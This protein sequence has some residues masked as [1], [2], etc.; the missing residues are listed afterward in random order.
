MFERN[1]NSLQDKFT[2]LKKK[3]NEVATI[4]CYYTNV[5]T[6]TSHFTLNLGTIVD[7]PITCSFASESLTVSRVK[8]ET[9]VSSEDRVNRPANWEIAKLHQNKNIVNADITGKEKII[10]DEIYA[11]VDNVANSQNNFTGI[12]TTTIETISEP[13]KILISYLKHIPGS[14]F[15]AVILI[16]LGYLGIKRYL[17][18]KQADAREDRTIANFHA[19][20][21]F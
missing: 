1:T 10:E 2:V 17:K 14:F 20:N 5:G 19:Q 21:K 13:F 12:V 4:Q 18:K 7:L 8:L 6:T 16:S 15:A 3:L 9:E 11:Q